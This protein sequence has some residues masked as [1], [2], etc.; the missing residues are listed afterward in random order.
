M[1]L[2][3]HLFVFYRANLYAAKSS[4]L[5]QHIDD[6]ARLATT[7]RRLKHVSWRGAWKDEWPVSLDKQAVDRN[8]TSHGTQVLTSPGTIIAN[9]AGEANVTSQCNNRGQSTR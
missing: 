2:R 9:K 4:K 3:R 8:G 5:L 1:Y 6:V 7:T